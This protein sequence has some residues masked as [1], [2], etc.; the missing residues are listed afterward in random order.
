M[1]QFLPLLFVLTLPLLTSSSPPPCDHDKSQ[2]AIP[3]PFSFVFGGSQAAVIS[4]GSLV[5]PT[6]PYTNIPDDAVRRAYAENF[7]P[8]RPV[9]LSQNILIIDLPAGR[10]M[11][12]TGSFN[13]PG[14]SPRF[15][16]AGRMFESLKL[17]GIEP[18]S[19]EY[20]MLSHAHIDHVGGLTNRD[21]S[22]AFP[23]ATVFIN[24]RDHE[25]WTA[26]VLNITNPSTPIDFASTYGLPSMLSAKRRA[27]VESTD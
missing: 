21:G 27:F 20:I 9:L 22:A 19:I 14:N 12:D 23:N 5:F 1:T 16:S 6:L 18:E 26:D 3:P 4:D 8:S 24:K 13:I 7:Q 11:L 15:S 17:A 25:F 2:S 10:V